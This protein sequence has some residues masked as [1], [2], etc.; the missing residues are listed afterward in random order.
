MLLSVIIPAH[1]EA[2]LIGPCLD[3]VARSAAPGLPGEVI[4]VTNGCTDDTAAVAARAR[5][6]LEAAGWSL[7]IIELVRSGKTGALTAGD[8]AAA[9]GIRAYLDADVTVS[10][11]LLREVV[12]TLD[13]PAPRYASG[14][15]RIVGDGPV[16]R[17]YA[18]LWARVPY[19]ARTVPG[20]G[21]FAMNAAGRARWSDWPDVIADDLFA[22]LN[23]TPEE[24]H[25]VDATYDWPIA[26][27]FGRLVRVRRRQDAGVSEIARRF[28]ELLRNED[29]SS[30]AGA[31]LALRDPL[32]FAVY[33]GVALA[34]RLRRQGPEWSRGR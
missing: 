20:C 30:G 31:G 33:A 3:A 6:D 13:V 19:M 11:D 12:H 16:S 17:A 25:S 34:V 32:G 22:R 14:R 24:R 28:P 4:V 10:S 15:V 23:F 27:G 7:R 1:N 29:K 2:A 9:G 21:F 18:R 5:S 26:R 8:R